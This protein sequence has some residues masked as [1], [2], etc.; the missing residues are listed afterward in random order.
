M[1]AKAQQGFTILEVLVAFLLAT[2]LLAV[3]LSGFSTGLS[4]L[5]RVSKTAQAAL[6]AQS[7][8]AE[9]GAVIPLV[10]GEYAGRAED[11]QIAYRWQVRVVPFEWSYSG[12]LR[13]QGREMYKVEVDV[14]WPA[15]LGEH[16]YQLASLRTAPNEAP[17]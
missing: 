13:E 14:F 3:I 2:M 7:R 5:A 9:V 16:Q 11:K 6:V 10:E 8:L 17:Q 15:P 4:G 1:Q 12:A